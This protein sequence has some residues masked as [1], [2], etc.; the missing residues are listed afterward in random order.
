[1][2]VP[3]HFCEDDPALLLEVMQRYAFATLVSTVDGKPFA[4]H[5]PVLARQVDGA[6]QI[7]GHVARANPHWQALQDDPT[8]LVI[9][10]G[11]HTY[12]SPTLYV[13]QNRVPTWNYIAVHASGTA[14]I[15]HDSDAKLALLAAL[16]Q[17]TEPGYQPQFD[18][19]DSGLRT[20]LLKAIVGFTIRVDQLEGK[21]KL[22]QHR[23]AEDQP[24]MQAWHEAGG[25]N[26]R[27]IARWMQRLGHWD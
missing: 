26:E 27:A 4:T 17:H 3:K 13:G 14:V 11:P 20:G 24:G 15:E 2:Y 23:L 25:D 1:M 16:V 19:L 8:A 10:Q 21:F 18:Q 12:I 5:V 22:G 7:D 9:F 6:L